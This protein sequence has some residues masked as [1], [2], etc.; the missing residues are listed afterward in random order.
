M[1][2][3]AASS[4]DPKL[5]EVYDRV[6]GTSA[7]P[8]KS[9][10]LATNPTPASPLPQPPKM[11]TP[12]TPSMPLPSQPLNNATPASGGS[13]P[14]T[15]PPLNPLEKPLGEAVNHNSS[16]SPLGETP[17][18]TQT[19]SNSANKTAIDYAALA[20][21]YATPVPAIGSTPEIPPAPSGKPPVVTP[22]TTAY[23]VV[24]NG[25]TDTKSTGTASEKKKSSGMKKILL[26]LGIPVLLIA[27]TAIWVV[28][29]K[30]DIMNLLP[31][32]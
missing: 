14:A 10:P 12:A 22:S 27:Y 8:S 6:M 24:N 5:K 32:S 20:A 4:L 21:K 31:L 15:T 18:S 11:P 3:K 1:D 26:I 16:P 23:G 9:S 30:V 2:P 17:L 7:T 28:V 19:P 29:F 13:P 25:K